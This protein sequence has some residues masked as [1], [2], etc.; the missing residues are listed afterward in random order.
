MMGNLVKSQT[1]ITF[2]SLITSQLTS[3]EKIAKTSY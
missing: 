1:I 3:T 2:E